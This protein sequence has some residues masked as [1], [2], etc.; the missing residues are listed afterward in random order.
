MENKCFITQ[1]H[2][3]SKDLVNYTYI[4]PNILVLI[5]NDYPDFSTSD[6]ISHEKLNEYRKVYLES[7]LGQEN[8][9]LSE[10]EIEVVRAIHENSI[11]SDLLEPTID[12][13]MTVGQKL[14]DRI[15]SFGGSWTFISIF[16]FF[17]IVWMAINIVYL[18]AEAFDPYPF[19][20]LNLILSCLAAIQAPII[21]MSQ[22]RKEEKD[23]KKAEY[24][25]KVNLKAELEIRLLN[26]KIDHLIIHQN[27]RLI[28][29]QKLQ[30]DYLEELTSKKG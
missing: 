27:Q 20:L 7:L 11:L 10:L 19:I 5:K 8:R 23:R 25:Y 18:S 13:Q 24:E 17:L 29:I 6:S 15:A 28:D 21:M 30:L 3:P 22:N 9:E 2:L 12:A 16:F 4:N 26:E 1:K 14:A